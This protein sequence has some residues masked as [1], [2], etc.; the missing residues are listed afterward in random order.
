MKI[1]D[2]GETPPKKTKTYK[3][4]KRWELKDSVVHLS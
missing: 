1:I 4:K 3:I 2:E